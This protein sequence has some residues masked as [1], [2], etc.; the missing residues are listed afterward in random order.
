MGR[1]RIGLQFFVSQ[2]RAR[3]LLTVPRLDLPMAVLWAD[4]WTHNGAKTDR[5]WPVFERTGTVRFL[6]EVAVVPSSA[7]EHKRWSR[8]VWCW[9]QY[10]GS[11][12]RTWRSA[13]ILSGCC[14]IHPWL[15]RHGAEHDL[16][17]FDASDAVG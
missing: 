8:L 3:G 16:R 1:Y 14:A 15:R 4:L 5:T 11:R 10:V 2:C 17:Q 7:H 12:L 6:P 13:L 9:L